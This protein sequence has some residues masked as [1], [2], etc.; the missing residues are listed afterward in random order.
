MFGGCIED[1]NHEIYGGLY[2]QRIFGESFEEPP[3]GGQPRGWRMYGGEWTPDGRGVHV[4]PDAGPKLVCETPV[5]PDGT[6]QAQI[7]LSDEL[8][9][10]AG[11]LI[12]IRNAGVGADS[13]DGYEIAFSA[14]NRSLLLGKHRHDYHLL[15]S[16]SLS[17]LAAGWHTLRVAANGPRIRVYLDGDT[18]PRID[19]TDNENPLLQG[20]IALRAWNADATFRDVRLN[21]RLVPLGFAGDGVSRWWKPVTTGDARSRFAQEGDAFNGSLCQRIVDLGGSGHVGVANEGLNGWGIA[22]RKGHAMMGRIYLHGNVSDAT[23]AL[24]SADGRQTYAVQK[25]EVGR[26]WGRV[27]FKL[28]PKATDPSARFAV[29]IDR[30]GSLWADQA[31]L[32]DAPEERFAGLPVRRDIAE[33]M[34]QNGI[35]FL[36]YG[37]T[38]VNAIDYRWKNMIG[39]RDRRAPYAGHWYPCSSNG[40]GIFDFLNF[41]DKAKI[42]SAFAISA[43]ESP[44]DAADLADYLAAPVGTKWGNRRAADGHP[45]PY[46][47]DYI[48]IGN[49]EG[50]ARLDEAALRLYAKQ[51]LS[52]ARAIHQ[53]N[54][55]LKLV[56]AA[57]WNPELPATQDFF[58][59]IDGEAAAW[60][61]HIGGDDPHS[62]DDAG[63]EI[64]QANALF[65]R[66]N[67]RTNV[68]VVVFEENGGRHDVQRGLGHASNLI[69]T[70]DLGDFVRADCAANMLQPL[71]QNDNGWDQGEIFFTPDHAWA[72]P[73]A[74]VHRLISHPECPLIVPVSVGEPLRGLACMSNDRR[75]IFLTVLNTGDQ[76]I[77]ATLSVPGFAGAEGWS[78]SGPLDAVNGAS[79]L[80]TVRIQKL[81]VSDRSISLP[82]HSVVSVRLMREPK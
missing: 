37:G 26:T 22:V 50:I 59:A 16:V 69:A 11:L 56:C 47:P 72:M 38:M 10:N 39:D 60:D 61:L 23:V 82:S 27:D 40:F 73:P 70:N 57:W 18:Q 5:A 14:K 46:H 8:G 25:V 76:P 75:T 7:E 13:F 19:Y 79:G 48:E 53:R 49:E 67:P 29:W 62:G 17:S 65:H 68:K 1:V 71:Q 2:D 43:E 77:D 80:P 44:E 3:A 81:P 34:T 20:Q 28:T 21:G 58:H 45:R 63:R 31:T 6:V 51:F 42:G 4:R 33:Q 66:W 64:A 15:D 12:R 35:R 74:L 78:V 32:F 24:Q 30:P 52:I 54:R 41:C 36:R 55:D 9:D